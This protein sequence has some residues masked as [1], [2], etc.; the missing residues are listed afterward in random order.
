MG[1]PRQ[2]VGVQGAA[3]GLIHDVRVNLH[4]RDVLVPQQ[5]LQSTEIGT[6]GKHVARERV[7]QHM[8]RHA[9]GCNTGPGGEFLERLGQALT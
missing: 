3:N 2:R 9:G 5:F 8:R 1:P 6:S 7:T 4:G